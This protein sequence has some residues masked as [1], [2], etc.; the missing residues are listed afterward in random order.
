V[1]AF[2]TIYDEFESCNKDNDFKKYVAN[3]LDIYGIE[4]NN[5]AAEIEIEIETEKN[6][7]HDVFK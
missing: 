2:Q 1:R 6:D 4:D 3:N 5:E 7:E